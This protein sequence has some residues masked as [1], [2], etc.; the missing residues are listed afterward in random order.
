MY[1]G[2]VC[3]YILSLLPRWSPVSSQTLIY[4][5][6]AYIHIYTNVYIYA[7]IYVYIYLCMYVY[8]MYA[9]KVCGYVGFTSEIEHRI[10]AGADIHIYIY[11]ADIHIYIHTGRRYP[12]IPISAV[13]MYTGA[14]TADIHSI[15]VYGYSRYPLYIC[16]RVQPISA[17][18]MYTGTADIRCIYVYGYS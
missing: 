5:Y 9:G 2:E 3:G 7:Q 4:T 17:V 6:Y 1:A 11:T 18:Y 12:H 15:Y 13:Y 10:I 16:I 8:H 14:D